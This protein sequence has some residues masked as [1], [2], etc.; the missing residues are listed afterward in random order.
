[1]T[2]GLKM[3][4]NDTKVFAD[5]LDLD[6]LGSKSRSSTQDKSVTGHN[7]ILGGGRITFEKRG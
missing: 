5:S 4:F 1:M 7:G 6:G 3:F 2:V